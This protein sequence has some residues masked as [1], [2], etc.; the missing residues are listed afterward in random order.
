MTDDMLGTRL[1]IYIILQKGLHI[2]NRDYVQFKYMMYRV[3]YINIIII[4][5]HIYIYVPVESSGSYLCAY[6][7]QILDSI[8]QFQAQIYMCISNITIFG[9]S[10]LFYFYY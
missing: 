9:S 1:Y 4:N 5:I 3:I 2:A 7:P 8:V 10:V 6:Y